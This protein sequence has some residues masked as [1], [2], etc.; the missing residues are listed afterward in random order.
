MDNLGKIVI[1]TGF[2]KLLQLQLIAQSGHTVRD[3]NYI[4]R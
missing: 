1:S 4:P 3:Q 2:Q